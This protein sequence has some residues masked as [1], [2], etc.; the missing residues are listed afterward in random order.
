M[1]VSDKCKLF[2]LVKF[3]GGLYSAR[4][5]KI[6][7]I[8]NATEN[9]LCW[10]QCHNQVAILKVGTCKNNFNIIRKSV[11]HSFVQ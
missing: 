2:R 9:S 7:Q 4:G 5:E 6:E 1:N 3:K 8:H 11:I 10:I